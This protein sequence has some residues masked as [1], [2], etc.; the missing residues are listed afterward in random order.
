MSEKFE[1]AI[2]AALIQAAATLLANKQKTLIERGIKDPGDLYNDIPMRQHFSLMV[3][4]LRAA[5]KTT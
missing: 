1:P 3:Q 4:S 2:E 5:Y